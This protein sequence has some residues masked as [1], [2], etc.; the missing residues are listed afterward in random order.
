MPLH[1]VSAFTAS[2][3]PDGQVMEEGAWGLM[4]AVLGGANVITNAGG[5]LEGGLVR[6]LGKAVKD[7]DLC[8]KLVAFAQDSDLSERLLGSTHAHASFET[9]F[10]QPQNADAKPQEQ[11]WPKVRRTRWA[12]RMSAVSGASKPMSSRRP[13]RLSTTN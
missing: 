4:L 8:G 7:A 10:F 3:L 11:W 9:A 2:R 1:T 13:A 6:E 5:W 12:G